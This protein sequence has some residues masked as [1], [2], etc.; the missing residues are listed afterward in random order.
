[1]NRD[2]I[3]AKAI[4]DAQVASDGGKGIKEIMHMNKNAW[5]RGYSMKDNYIEK[6]LNLIASDRNSSF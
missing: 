4:L 6:A 3:V 5:Y 1:M 2:R